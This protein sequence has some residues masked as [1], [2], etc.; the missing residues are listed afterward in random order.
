MPYPSTG[1]SIINKIIVDNYFQDKKNGFFIETG[2]CDGIFQSNTFYL[3]TELNWTGLLIEPNPE[4]AKECIINRPKSKVYDCALVSSDYESDHT[5]LYSLASK[6]AMGTVESRGIWKNE[7][8]VP[9]VYKKVP[10]RTL[11]SILEEIQP[12]EIDLFSLDV[13]GYELN[14]LRGL[15]FKKYKPKVI[16]VECHGESIIPV[17]NLLSVFYDLDNKISD[18][19]YVY[20]LREK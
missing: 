16:V 7:T 3:E 9:I 14:V 1:H 12:K 13:E 2:S 8:E 15:N 20:L 19:D 5:I 4:Y 6:G 11:T 17:N 10:V 18:R